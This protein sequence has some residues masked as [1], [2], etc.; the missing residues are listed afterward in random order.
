MTPDELRNNIVRWAE[1]GIRELGVVATLQAVQEAYRTTKE[2]L[3]QAERTIQVYDVTGR[4]VGKTTPE[5][6]NA[7]VF[8]GEGY[9]VGPTELRMSVQKNKR[10]TR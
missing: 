5:R 1:Y 7:M 10:R 6:A 4:P 2:I 3:D 8:K 9:A